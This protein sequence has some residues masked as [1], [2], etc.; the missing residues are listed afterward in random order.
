VSFIA[1][2]QS[3]FRNYARFTG[4]ARRSEFWWW[5]LFTV[6]LQAATSGF[7]DTINGLASLAVLI[8]SLAVHVRRLHD[9]NRSGW[10]MAAPIAG[11]VVAIVVFVVFGVLTA[12]DLVDGAEWDPATAFDGVSAWAIALLSVGLLVALVTGIM[13][14]VFLLQRSQPEANRFGPPPPPRML[15]T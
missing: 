14:L 2:I 13:N 4:R 10:W 3:G 5:T 6:I 15:P 9:T 11:I 12:F 1:A 8:P 7:G